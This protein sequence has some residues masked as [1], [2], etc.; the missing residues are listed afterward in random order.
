MSPR[1]FN[2]SIK[3]YFYHNLLTKHSFFQQAKASFL[4]PHLIFEQYSGDEINFSYFTEPK[5]LKRVC[6]NPE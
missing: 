5:K 2:Q 4:N 1:V 3:V 6:K